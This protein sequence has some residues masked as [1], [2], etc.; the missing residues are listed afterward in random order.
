LA[1]FCTQ[2]CCSRVLGCTYRIVFTP[3]QSSW[4]SLSE[5]RAR[6]N[7]SSRHRRP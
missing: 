2:R 4:G 7:V 6:R 3:A 5:N 1:V